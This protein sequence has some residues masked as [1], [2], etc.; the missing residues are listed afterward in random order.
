MPKGIRGELS[1]L[2]GDETVRVIV[3]TSPRQQPRKQKNLLQDAKA[4]GY[5]DFFEYL[6]DHPFD[7]PNPV[8]YTREELHER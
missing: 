1:T 3:L 6:M 5:D 2:T 7:V 8:R 4:Q